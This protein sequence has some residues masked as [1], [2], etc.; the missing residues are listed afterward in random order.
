MSTL[1]SIRLALRLLR[2]CRPPVL[3][4]SVFLGLGVNG[5]KAAQD[6]SLPAIAII[7]DDLDIFDE[8]V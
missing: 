1:R 7:I 5:P 2:G 4:L 3:I 8:K 6:N